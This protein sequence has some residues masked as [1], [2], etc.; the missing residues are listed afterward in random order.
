MSWGQTINNSD[1]IRK[2]DLKRDLDETRRK[3][4]TISVFKSGGNWYLKIKTKEGYKKVE[5]SDI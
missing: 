1:G 5:L 3:L 2:A 4:D